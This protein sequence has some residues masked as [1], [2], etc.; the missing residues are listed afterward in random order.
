MKSKIL[1]NDYKLFKQINKNKD[2]YLIEYIIL[3]I[4]IIICE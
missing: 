2:Y 4:S 1:N 3:I